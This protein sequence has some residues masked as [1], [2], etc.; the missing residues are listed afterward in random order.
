MSDNQDTFLEDLISEDSDAP[1]R[2]EERPNDTRIG[3]DVVVRKDF[4]SP[5]LNQKPEDVAFDPATGQS[6]EDTAA[7]TSAGGDAESEFVIFTTDPADSSENSS[8]S[9]EQTPQSADGVEGPVDQSA[10]E[11]ADLPGRQ[12]SSENQGVSAQ[13]DATGISDTFQAAQ[14]E[15]PVPTVTPADSGNNDDGESSD[16]S[17]DDGSGGGGGPGSGG[18]SGQAPTDISATGGA[19]DENAGTGTVVATLST[20]DSDSG[21]SFTYALTN[22]PSGFFE[23]VGDEIRVKAGANID[24]ENAPSH[25][26]TIEV[27]DSTGNSYSETLTL[28][29]NNLM[30]E[31][32]T[33]IDQSGGSVD[34]NAPA[35]TVVATLST[36]DADAGDSFSYVLT[37]DPSGFFEIVGDEIRV[38]AGANI[39]F[40]ADQSHDVTVEVTDAG[41]NTYAEVLTLNVNN[42]FDEAPTGITAAGGAI[43]EN[44]AAGSLVATLS[45][46]DSDTGDTF[47]YAITNDPSGFFEIVGDEIRVKAGANI[48]FEADETHDVTVEVTDAG[49]NTYSETITLSVNNLMDEGPTDITVAG[50]AVD[51]NAAAGTVVATLSTVDADAGD[52][53]TYSLTSDASG[54]FEIVGDEIRVKAGADIDFEADQSH[55]VTVEVTDA[56]GNTYS[57]TITLSVNNLMDE[58]PT[59]ITVAGGSVDENAAAGTVVATLS[60]VDADAGDS[61]TY[62][63]T[64]D[65]SGFFEIVGDEIRVKVG[66][67]IDFEA[68]ET[69]DV[70]VEVTDAGGN[71]Y[72]ETI[73]LSVN[74]LMDEGP[75]DIT[76]AGGAVDENAAAGTVVATLS[77]VDADAGDSFTY[78]LTADASGFF[79][80]VGDEIRVKAGA[81]IDFEADETHDLT[82]EVTDAG[83]NT[84]SETIT[85]SV[86][87]LM[88]EGPTDISV[89]GGSVDENAAAGTVVATLSTVDA[90]AGDSF[91]YSLTSDASGFFEIVGDEIRVKSGA[92]IDFESDQSHD[93]TVEVTDAGGNTYS[94]TITL[95]VNNLMDEGPTDITVAG[96]AVDENAS[97][98]TVVATLSTVDADAGDSFTYSLTADASGFFE[99]VGDEIRVKAGANIDFEAD[100]THDVTVEVTDAGGNTYSETITLSVNN[101]MDEGPTDIT[102]A[103]GS[104]DENAAAGTV[105]ATLSTVDADAGDSFTYALTADASGFFEIVGDEI[106]V[107]AGAD[108]DFESDQSHD[109][110]VEVTDAG[111]N[112][113]SET[114]TLSVNNLMDEGPT[115]ITV[116]G[117]SVDENA[118]A[119]TVVATLSTVDADSGDSFTYSLTADASGFFEIVGDEIRV[120]AG[121]AI[122][123][124]ADETHDLTVEV[125]DAG[126]NT[127][128]GTIT[129]SVNNLMDEGPTDISV[130][131]GSVDENAAAGTVVATLST[132][133]AD[134]GDSF[135]Y[136]LTADASGFFE[137]V[138]DEIRVKAGAD[139]DF[140]SDQSHDV[141]VEVTDA[142]GNT[143][144]E[145]ITLSV[146]N[147]MDEGPTD[148]TVA[149]GSVDENATA[150]TVVA[151]LSTVDADAGDS[152]TYSLTSDASGFF[153]I[154]GDE[155]RVKA[156]AAIDFEADETH[157]VTVQVT[158]AG[159]NTYSETITLSVNNL[160]DEGPTDITVAGGSVDEN[161]SAGTVVATLSTVDADAGDSFTYSL[162]SDASGFF[163]IVGD[164]I[165]VKAGAAIDFEADETHDVSVQV[166]DAGGN[167]YSETITLSVNNLMDEGPTDITVAGGS[168]DENAAA[169]TVVATLST[170]DADAGDSFTY[171]LT[172]DASGFFEIVGDEIRVKSGAN[173]DFEADQSH[174]V[175]VQVT[176]AGGNTYSETITLSVNNLMDEGPTDITVAG[177]SVDENASAGTVV[178]TLSTVDADAGDSF[179][180][181]LTSDASGFFEIVG[182][183]IRVKAGAAIDF[184]AD[185]THDVSVQV[186]D[187]G[188]NTYSE[189]ITLSV[190]NLMDEGPTDIT[191]AGGSVDEN[192]AAGT[193]VA[194]LST[195]DADAGDSFT[196]ALTA[197]ASGFFE[198]VG[199]EI[200]VKSGANIDF[201]ADQ[202]HD[203]TVQVTDAGGNTYSETITLSV[204]NLMDEG[205]TDITVAGGSVDEN[206]AAG[207]VVATLSTVDADAG[208]SFTYSLTADA[209]GFFE[210]V[211]DEIRVKA[212][213]D[214]DYEVDQSHDVTVEVTD[215]GGN[216]Y[217]ETITLSVNNL[218][219][220]GPTDITVAGGSVDENASAGTVVATLSTVDA[221][222]GDSFTYALTADA[223]GFFEIV[224]DEI[225]VKSGAAIDYEVDQSHD[226]TVEVTDAGGN[227]YSETITLSVNNLMDEGPTDITVAGG[228]VDE[229]AAAGT[230]VVTLSTVDADAG[231]S[232]TYSLTSDASGFFEIVGDEI[233]VKAGAAI[234][235]EA[236]ETHDVTVQVTDAGG[237]T[238]SETITLSVN[239]LMDEGPTDIAV[240]GGSVDE[241]AAAGTVVAT[242]STVDADAGDSFTYS[243]TADASG[244]FEIVGDEIRVKAGAA[245]DFE[246]DQSHDV[247]VQVTDAGGNT[248]NETITLS[249]NNLMDEGPTDI[250][251]AGGS[252]DEN[253]A[254]GTVVATLSTVDA[255]AGD[256]F[257]YSLTS[258]ASGFFE[259]VGDEIRVKA[260]AAIDFEADETHDVTVQVTDAG[261]NTYSETITLS[262]NN[263]MD[264]GPTDITVA[265]G[266]VDENAAAGTVV[267]TLSTV[268]ADAGD[269]FTYSLTSD[270]NG[271]FEIVG[272]E[273]RV[274]AGA[275]IDFESDQSHD[276]T[277]EVTDAGGNTYSET[278]TLSV[279][280]LMDEGPTDITVAGGSVD[281]NASAGTV[282]ATLSTVDADA[283]D[284]FTYSLTADASGFFE[285]VG[286]E[287]R[288]KSGAAID[289]EADETHDV[290]VEVTDAGGNTYSETITLSVNNLIDEGPTDITVAGGSVDENAAAGTVV[291]TLSTVDADAGDSFTYSLTSDASGFFEIVGD[292]IRVKAGADIDF[293]ADQSHD[294]TV[295]VTDAGGNTYSETITLSVNNLMDEGPTDITVAGGSVDENAAAGTVV[296]TL[297]TVDADAG[298]SFTYSLTSDASGF[299]EIVGDEIR[300][301]A[302]ADIDFEADQSHD[303]TVEVTDAG[304]NT[305]SETITLSVNNL[306][307]EGPTD[308]TVAGGS[309]DENAAAGTVV[310]TLSTVDADAGD[311]FTYSL[312]ADASGF[313]EI[314]G[315]EIRVKAGADIDF[316]ADETHD[317]TVEVT[318]A[319]G[320]TYSETITLSVNNLMDEGPTDITVAGGSVDENAAAGTVVATLSTVDA[321]AGDSFT[322]SLTA[323][324][325][326][327]FEIVGDEIRVKAGAAIDFETDETHDVTVEVT[328]AGGNTY[329]ETITL[330]VNN[331]MDEGPT[332]ITVAG[333]AVDE[334]ASAG[335]VVATLSTVDADAGDSF[336]YSLTSDASGFFEI[337]GDEIRVKSGAAIDFESDQSHDVTVQ[338]TD[339][340]GNTYSETVTLSVNNLMDEGP[341]DITVAGGSVDENAA[342]GTVVATL[343][344]VDADAGDSFTYNL[345]A[346]A[347]G[348][349]EIVG[350]EI[351]VKAGAAIDFES[352]Q[353]HDVTVEVTDAGGNTYSETI[354]LS[355]NNLMDEGPT[356]ITVAGGSVDENAAAGTVVATLSTVDAD[357]GDSF[358]Y[359]LTADASGFFEIVGD[360]IRVKAGAAIDFEADQSHDVT[361]QVTDAGG[362]TYSE[363]ITL[364]VN[365]LM[366]EGPTD[367]TVAG[368]SVDENAA[369][370]TVV[371]TLST[372][373]ADAGDSFTYALT[374]DASGFF[375]IV[376][377]EIRVKAGAAID[378]EADQ[379]HDVTVE[380]TDAGGNTYSETITLSVNNLM[381]EG[382]TD[383]TVAGGSVDENAAA[384]TVVATL[385]TVD[386]DAGDTF[387]YS[388]TSDASGFF[389]IVGDEIRVKAGAAIDFEADQ[390]HDVTVEVTDAGGNTYSE[391]ITLSVNNLMDEGPTDI[392]VAGGSV[393][394]NAA[395]G[396]VVATLSTVDADAGDSFTYNLT[397][398]AS[399]FFEIVGDEIRVK[400]GAAIDFEADETHDVTVEVT[401]AGGNTYSETITLSVNNLMDEGPTDIE[402]KGGSVNENASAG[403]VVAALSTVDADAGDSFTYSLTSDASGFF[404]IV[405]NEIRVK[406][407]AN[408]DF[409][410]DETHDVTVEVTDAGGNTYSETITLNV[411]NVNEA[412][413]DLLMPES[414]SVTINNAGFEAQTIAD[415]GYSNSIDGWTTTGSHTGVWNAHSASYTDEA[416][417]G[418]NAAFID[419]GGTI[420][421]TLGETFTPGLSYSLSAMVGDEKF[422]GDSSGWEI[423]LYAGSQLLGS[424]SNT[425][426]D[427]AD[428]S[429]VDATLSLDSSELA[430]FSSY[431]GEALRIE[432][433]DSGGAANVHFDDIRLDATASNL[434]SENAANGT[435]ITAVQGVTDPDAGDT[436]TYSLTDDAGG[437]FAIDANTG[438]ITVADSSLID[439]AT[440][441]NPTVTVQVTDS[442]SNTYSEVVTI[443]VSDVNEAPTDLTATGVDGLT[444]STLNAGTV[445]GDVDT[446]DP[447]AGDTHTYA[448]TDDAS[449]MFTID[450]NTGEISVSGSATTPEYTQRTGS[451]NPFDGIDVGSDADAT[452]IDIDNDGDLDLFVGAN[453]GTTTYYENTGSSTSPVYGS[454]TSNPFGLSDIGTDS[455]ITFADIDNDGDMDA[456]IGEESGNINFFRN[457]GNATSPSFTQV[458]GSSNPFDGIDV[459][460][461]SAPFLVDLD[462]DGDLD[463]I[464]GESDGYINYFRNDGSAT[465]ASYTQLSGSSNPFNGIDVGNDASPTLA[466]MDG[467]GDLDLLTGEESGT[468]TYFE[469]SGNST[470]PSFSTSGTSNP[471]GLSD[472][473][474]DSTVMLA[475]MDGDGDLDLIAAE[476]DDGGSTSG[477]GTVNYFENTGGSVDTS[478]VNSQTVT[479]EVTDSAGNTYSE[480]VGIHFGTSGNDSITGTSDTDI[481]YGFGGSDTL[482]GGGGDDVIY[483]GDEAGG[484][485]PA[486]SILDLNPVSYWRLGESSGSTATDETGN[487]NAVYTNVDYGYAGPN[488]NESN[489]GVD[490]DGSGDYVRVP[491]SSDLAPSAGTVQLWFNADSVSGDNTLVSKVGGGEEFNI[492]I[493]DGTLYA[494]LGDEVTGT[495]VNTGE[496]NQIS[497]S[498]GSSGLELYLNGNLVASDSGSSKT[499]SGNN[500]DL[501]FGR[502]GGGGKEFD[503]TIDEIAFFD[504]Q[505]SSTDV[506]NLY[507]SGLNGIPGGG[508]GDTITG[509]DGND[510]LIGGAGD[511]TIYGD[512]GL[513]DH[514]IASDGTVLGTTDFI[515]NGSFENVGGSGSQVVDSSITGW[516]LESGSG[517]ESWSSSA[518]WWVN[519]S[520]TIDGDR[521]L[522][523]D[524]GGNVRISQ[525]VSGLTDGESYRVTFS[526]ADYTTA[527]QGASSGGM[528]V[529]WNG[530]LLGSVGGDGN[531]D[532]AD[533]DF[534]LVAGSGD[535]SNKLEFE[536]T[537][538][539][540]AWGAGLDNVRVHE[541]LSTDGTVPT[542]GGGTGDDTLIGGAGADT[543]DGGAGTDAADYS[544]SASAVTVNLQTGTGTGGDAQG[545]TLTNIE[546]IVGSDY[547]DTLTGDSGANTLTGGAGADALFG[548]DGSDLFV[549]GTGDGADTVDGGAGA[550]WTDTIQL[551]NA[552]GSDVASGWTVVLDSGDTITSTGSDYYE[553]SQDA[554]GTITLTDGS[555]IDFDNVERIEW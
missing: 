46:T 8:D 38:K 441:P 521:H 208:D 51:E 146:N 412:P 293:E 22:D 246:A 93:V 104:V 368:G 401:D 325:S 263:L 134:A 496:W 421:Q 492:R 88:D 445:V 191:V 226:V 161:A 116:A 413:T 394:E 192:A 423:R 517:I 352:D 150:G 361:V 220:E 501:Y 468:F 36:V 520:S 297:S 143:Y 240:A 305:Y 39:D 197:D 99:I 194:T 448:L 287:I 162:T 477:S 33:D 398:D 347:S 479:V 252:V 45:T 348:F 264:A 450:A 406:A 103:G 444:T 550:T 225:R 147:L 338:V 487:N 95:S 107:K 460:G 203:V 131:G 307:D 259:I 40:E 115:D 529:Y 127:H 209:S 7:G 309:V 416:P 336:T 133:D 411:N 505:L 170:V 59:D 71:T 417:E 365:N 515:V 513:V 535:G 200:R 149:G 20:V 232:F 100:E 236:D 545:D 436:H 67:D 489:T 155:I 360:E 25:D 180:Y 503:G 105:V 335:T 272:D 79:E 449:G 451:S 355:V 290:T 537:G 58:G 346:D 122:D 328:D 241:N 265:G 408:I 30:D 166:T 434:V 427:P 422:A 345:T 206:A 239:N 341:T 493:T 29:V 516:N 387:T 242:L 313:F 419:N 102:V 169:G 68:D 314:V 90:D 63:L 359:A 205:P 167:T 470:T 41:G 540:D 464:V 156:G 28:N 476:G 14:V 214:I 531:R 490:L 212:G 432:L 366:D 534:D 43:D 77:T 49:G 148:I 509:G 125:T 379:S 92:N 12:R 292:E 458:T 196:Y 34:E 278:I 442:G 428:D 358:T 321:D 405:G 52:S 145:T 126:G 456:F 1:K 525:D 404:E 475:D 270:A 403:T 499:L 472:I 440:N 111:G 340:G 119:G 50:G 268:D 281:E 542:A 164:Q 258:D 84:H 315:D 514:Q 89:A 433:Y 231:D 353:S 78:A 176:D 333:G 527:E 554:S 273:I 402:V 375:E 216:T 47:V 243:L 230:V 370:G 510:T 31:S 392:T 234:D 254:A 381:D 138:G 425:D 128:S 312:T 395:A 280:N 266:S 228:S 178:A 439:Y 507:D 410:A 248:Y 522:D 199:D 188:G 383:I 304:G 251:V 261:G 190:N 11:L 446:V 244:F 267:A 339:A 308:I 469:N 555:S 363:T 549:F 491:H 528:N 299:F 2:R 300:V 23:I 548:G 551:Q 455:D 357:A 495:T 151:T 431:Y 75:T 82:V 60:T 291:A 66:A 349:F 330:S 108:I 57:E 182:D 331:L 139:I 337:V 26:V 318:D 289:F 362:N 453:D 518:A 282:V 286:D 546:N 177:G 474:T 32:P 303:V 18:G 238:Y 207:T 17:G 21:D 407:G 295:E 153:E 24:F 389:E 184:E 237:N 69:H 65:A 530:E 547:A 274:K 497:F 526:F 485:D 378:F 498:W 221:D 124:E 364:S 356:D 482:N 54:F 118:A 130:A 457:D 61:F 391:T 385:G 369:A 480:N 159:G 64:A 380:V 173:I 354:T 277:V 317:V 110:T 508:G 217:S 37:N 98:G 500:G 426:F 418:E 386:A 285:I 462:G 524:Y 452:V 114:I 5:A 245:I 373:D 9:E 80:I 322:Y 533:F 106:R 227:T 424:V 326:G 181:S 271:F 224:G 471:W 10:P 301:K 343:S 504:Q 294:V 420:S 142:G 233:R 174:D 461:D 247:T 187:A 87:N 388:L 211:G 109:V 454:G 324:A 113:Y 83:G 288:V 16:T 6:E 165:R 344:T 506:S 27:T 48:D 171:A 435:V 367:I 255:D 135:T 121:A 81:A 523:L 186:T 210:I 275:A 13:D 179:T 311:S 283:G 136:S 193:V 72:S 327:F 3:E 91:T 279:N 438:T 306:M 229:N 96:G 250:T 544:D 44:S 215:A 129:L 466:D 329:S 396:T 204:N 85:L 56:G 390:S 399:G 257:T 532:F 219:D 552:D 73:T 4:D 202:S 316:E 502:D 459:G 429:F 15:T 298:D 97:A 53:F 158:D 123:F 140:E 189:T 284:S 74:N 101:L 253:A 319:G 486:Q 235:F 372:V 302:G 201:E 473:G 384:G 332:D 323:D 19:V 350:D 463:A 269:S 185:E 94:E 144:S 342:A 310:A 213:A 141:T 541:I 120:K 249:V 481:I 465:S 511:D 154:V 70:T 543:L 430:A 494:K 132:V 168:V 262:V 320:N 35:G 351:R 256:S 536:G 400:A 195:V 371:A 393:D 382:P 218:M 447:D 163:E 42:L 198:I 296:A 276:V 223:S 488:S 175:T 409:E 443:N 484:A 117:G 137:I 478:S 334:N 553:L 152:F 76:V 157:D 467:D 172:A 260:G 376:G 112:T 397:A 62:S 374:A 538:S 483:G 437:A 414:H 415:G 539:A 377:D 512:A 222:A 160:M 519:D 183:Q 55:D 86:N